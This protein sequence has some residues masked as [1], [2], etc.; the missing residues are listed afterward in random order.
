MS[1]LLQ[2]ITI[3]YSAPVVNSIGAVLLSGSLTCLVGRN[4]TG[5]ST[6]LKTIAQLIPPLGGTLS[7]SDHRTGIVLTHFPDLSNTTVYELV[8]YGRLPH[9]N[10]I[11]SIR[12]SDHTAI[13]E[14]L[15]TVGITHYKDRLTSRL[16]DG[17]KQKVMI[18]RALAQ[19][20]DTLLLDEPSAFLDYPSKVALMKLLKDLAHHEGKAILLSTHDVELAKAYADYIWHLKDGKMQVKKPSEFIIEEV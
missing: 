10:L 5:K 17:E 2:D 11:A 19:G 13:L 7:L 4:G 12:P 14:A 9:Q 1:I 18:A 16:S 8:S 20:T 15:D 6:L 3:G